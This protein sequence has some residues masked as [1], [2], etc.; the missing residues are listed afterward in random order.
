[1][2]DSRTWGR[3][4]NLVF[5][6]MPLLAS[7]VVTYLEREKISESLAYINNHGLIEGF[8]D[9]FHPELMSSVSLGAVGIFSILYG[10]NE[11][12]NYKNSHSE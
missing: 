2:E 4:D 7:P 11:I 1:M 3:F 5:G 6:V 12:K 8:R 10:I 9:N